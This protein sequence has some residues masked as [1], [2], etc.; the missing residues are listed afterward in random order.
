MQREAVYPSRH[1][2]EADVL[3]LEKLCYPI[4]GSLTTEARELD[5]P[6]GASAVEMRPVLTP[7]MPASGP[8]PSYKRPH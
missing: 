3:E 5:A 1:T 7:T 6:K 2:V 8:L 4:V